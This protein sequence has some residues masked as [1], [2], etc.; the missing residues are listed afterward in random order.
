MYI[1][2]DEEREEKKID[3][4]RD[5]YMKGEEGQKQSKG[6]PNAHGGG[7]GAFVGWAGLHFLFFYFL[8]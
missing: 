5:T 1:Y 4:Y 6:F 3:G 2:I 7:G 8:F